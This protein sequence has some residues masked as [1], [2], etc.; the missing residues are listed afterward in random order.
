M[1]A[2]VEAST[3]DQSPS[4]ALISQSKTSLS[5]SLLSGDGGKPALGPKPHLMPKPFALQRNATI[6]PIKAPKI[7]SARQLPRAASSDAL[8]SFVSSKSELVE[9]RVQNTSESVKPNGTLNVSDRSAS[10]KPAPLGPK[11]ALTPKTDPGQNPD[12]AQKA[13]NT[14]PEDGKNVQSRARAKSLGSQEQK[15]LRQTPDGENR[16]GDADVRASSPCWAVRNRLS[17]GLTSRFE[18]PE[19]EVGSVRRDEPPLS[20]SA[21]KPQE[22]EEIS[23]CSIKRRISLL[24]DRSAASQHRDTFNKKDSAPA[25][26]SVDIKQRIKNLSLNTQ[27]PR[28]RLPSTGALKCLPHEKTQSDSAQSSPLQNGPAKTTTSEKNVPRKNSTLCS[29]DEEEEEDDDDDAAEEDKENCVSVPMYRRVGMAKD[30]ERK[31][32]EEEKQHK[33]EQLK[34]ERERE[35]HL[36]EERKLREE[37]ERRQEEERLKED[38]EQEEEKQRQR[39]EQKKQEVERQKRIEEERKLEEERKREAE[40][41]IRQEQERLEREKQIDEQKRRIEEN[42]EKE[43]QREEQRLRDEREKEKLRKVK[44]MEDERQRIEEE[45]QREEQRLRQEREKQER[46]KKERE[47]EE[48]RWIEEKERLRQEREMERIR[49]EREI[50]EERLR[51]EREKVER[52]KKER[53]MEEKRLLQ[54]QRLRQEREKQERLKKEREM[55]EKRQIEEEEQLR[56]EREMERIRK[57]REMEERRLLEEQRLRQEREKEER[58]KKEREM[59]ERR[60]IEEQRLRQERE[61]ERQKKEKEMEEQRLRQQREMERLRKEREMEEKRLR[62]ERDE[63]LKKEREM[64]E[65]RLV[66]DEKRWRQEREKERLRMEREDVAVSY[67]LI[68]FDAVETQREVSPQLPDVLYDDF[69]VKPRR[70]GTRTRGT[71]SP[72]GEAPS[73]D[74]FH[75]WMESRSNDP[76]SPGLKKHQN[77]PGEDQDTCNQAQTETED[78]TDSQT[79]RSTPDH[80]ASQQGELKNC[81]DDDDDDDDDEDERHTETRI[82]HESNNTDVDGGADNKVNQLLQRLTSQEKQ[83]KPSIESDAPEPLLFPKASAPLLDSSVFR[84]KADLGKKRSIKR[85]RPSRAVRQRAALP[86]LTEGSNPDWR[87]C[88]STDAAKAQNSESEEESSKYATPPPAPSQPKRVPV[89]PGMDQSALMAQLKRRSGRMETDVTEGRTAPAVSAR[90]PRTPT[91]GPRVLPPVNSR[92]TG[93]GSSPS[94]LRELKS[95]KRLS[96][97]ESDA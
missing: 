73:G 39:E 82:T 33:D 17:V 31:T 80:I 21:S 49:K 44:E 30:Q 43:R 1:A 84:A 71:P 67:D 28:V 92:D 32:Q 74:A 27:Q 41:E 16:S 42:R 47:M 78:P 9:T 60:G 55:E 22:D 90:S 7:S 51:Q 66:E 62:E 23:G 20:P 26:I 87:F 45:R 53:E 18:S 61:K 63:K 77:S 14:K 38:R 52:L 65:R 85:S 50:E 8:D 35:K 34:K 15:A 54:E 4:A 83:R 48:K 25:E 68:S 10:P 59:E 2:W 40:R 56:Q 86:A 94:W 81:D 13:P 37:M 91:L 96:R 5:A 57:E 64:E 70:W 76:E 69:S 29:A 79:H 88:D 75:D 11:P 89:F 24:F 95:K 72:S 97:P 6:R 58:L 36:E 19:R 12:I 46:I 93:S 3:R